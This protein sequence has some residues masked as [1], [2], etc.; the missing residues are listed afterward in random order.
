MAVGES[1]LHD[2]VRWEPHEYGDKEEVCDAVRAD[3]LPEI[4]NG[5]TLAIKACVPPFVI[6]L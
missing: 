6:F 1:P 5:G 4:T 3:H 2:F